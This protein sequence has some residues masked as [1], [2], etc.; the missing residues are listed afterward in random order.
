VC[1]GSP[2]PAGGIEVDTQGDAFF[3]AFG[4]AA[5]AAEAAVDGREALRPGPIQVRVG[6]HTGTPHLT[7]EGYISEDVHKARGSALRA[8][9]SS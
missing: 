8:A 5:E 7:D 2:S 1:C 6:I 4:S 9:R 3:S